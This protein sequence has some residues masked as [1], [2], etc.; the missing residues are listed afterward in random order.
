MIRADGEDRATGV[1]TLCVKVN[2]TSGVGLESSRAL[3]ELPRGHDRH[4]V[5]AG[6]ESVFDGR[7]AEYVTGFYFRQGHVSKVNVG[8]NDEHEF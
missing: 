3:V 7:A 2:L 5:N 8:V 1:V 6:Q 4:A